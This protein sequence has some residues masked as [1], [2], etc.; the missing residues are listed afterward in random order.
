MKAVV[1]RVKNAR[2]TVDETPIGAIGPGLVVLLGVTKEDT[3]AD[4]DFLAEKI[5]HLRIFEDDRGKMNKSLI[6]TGGELL[7]I[8][9]F[10]LAA[11][12]RKGRR[13]S[14]TR[15]A[16]PREARQLYHHFI[17]KTR[18]LGIHTETGRFQAM[19]DVSLV[20]SGPVTFILDTTHP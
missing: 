6:D 13:P 1:Q 19:M 15:A 10:T 3:V 14:F 16:P 7:V 20:N 8:S 17:K 2:V 18:T 4:A 9:Q 12:T 5:V 11:D